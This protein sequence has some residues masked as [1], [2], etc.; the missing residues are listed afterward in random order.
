MFPIGNTKGIQIN[1]A[2]EA[3]RCLWCF[4]RES[5]GSTNEIRRAKRAGKLLGCIIGNTNGIRMEYGARS[6]PGFLLALFRSLGPACGPRW[7]CGRPAKQYFK[8]ETMFSI[9]HLGRG[10]NSL[11][12]FFPFPA[13]ALFS[14]SIF[15]VQWTYLLLQDWVTLTHLRPCSLPP[16]CWARGKGVRAT[17]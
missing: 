15:I 5:K 13:G 1:T 7:A 6:A 8:P 14:G 17:G 4:Y 11:A 12:S 2:R 10:G 16:P 9:L 3:R